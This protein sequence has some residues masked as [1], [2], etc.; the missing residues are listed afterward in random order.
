MTEAPAYQITI[1]T[2]RQA[3]VI[4]YVLSPNLARLVKVL[5][6]GLVGCIWKLLAQVLLR[7]DLVAI[8]F[9]NWLLVIFRHLL[10]SSHSLGNQLLFYPFGKVIIVGDLLYILAKSLG[11]FFRLSVGCPTRMSSAEIQGECEALL[12]VFH[13][14]EDYTARPLSFEI[15]TLSFLEMLVTKSY[16]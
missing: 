1:C 5:V 3:S 8:V 6:V 7:K 16:F 13:E 15:C 14:E 2:A 10:H 11:N 12:H 4:T 9:R